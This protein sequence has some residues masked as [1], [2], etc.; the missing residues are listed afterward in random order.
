MK[1][2]KIQKIP[3]KK[4][5]IQDVLARFCFYYQ[6]Y[7]YEQAKKLPYIRVIRMLKVADRERAILLSELVDIAAAPHTKR[8]SGVG[9]LK[10]KY[11]K[12]IKE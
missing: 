2:I 7:T 11:E 1:V 10:S 12:I 5:S 8:G 3:Q 6:Q 9:K 4:V